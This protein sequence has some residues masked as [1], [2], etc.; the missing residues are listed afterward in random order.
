MQT[1]KVF[2]IFVY[3]AVRYTSNGKILVSFLLEQSIDMYVISFFLYS[4][5]MLCF[6]TY[7]VISGGNPPPKKLKSSEVAP[8]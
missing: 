8:S 6:Y 3:A 1:K 7:V 5:A 4:A 2:P